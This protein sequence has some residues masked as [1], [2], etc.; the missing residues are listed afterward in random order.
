MIHADKSR[1]EPEAGNQDNPLDLTSEADENGNENET[2]AF[3][4]SPRQNARHSV[5]VTPA[6]S[7]E[8]SPDDIEQANN[9]SSV[10]S[11]SD[12]KNKR[13]AEAFS[14]KK[15]RQHSLTSSARFEL[16]RKQRRQAREKIHA[17]CGKARKVKEGA[18]RDAAAA[19][20]CLDDDDDDDDSDA[21][22]GSREPYVLAERSEAPDEFVDFTTSL[23]VAAKVSSKS[24]IEKS[25]L[26][27]KKRLSP[28]KNWKGKDMEL[29]GRAAY[30][31]VVVGE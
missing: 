20:A 21:L 5:S 26:L 1:S 17:A 11:P 28:M 18:R 7:K 9:S 25:A 30:V 31:F 4:I 27:G 3:R 8:N 23:Q 22:L 6:V 14:A 16:V 19:Q 12:L 10:A 24:G 29:T 13:N 2:T 15:S